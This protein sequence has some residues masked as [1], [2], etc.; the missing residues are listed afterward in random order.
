MICAFLSIA[1]ALGTELPFSESTKQLLNI[2]ALSSK[3]LERLDAFAFR[4]DNKKSSFKKKK[5]FINYLNDQAHKD[6]L[7]SYEQL[8]SFEELV[9]IGKYNCLTGSTFFALLLERYD[10]AYK[11]I[12]T[13]YHMFILIEDEG[14]QYLLDATDPIQGFETNASVIEQ[15]LAEYKAK[16]SEANKNSVSFQFDL[17]NQVKT[18]QLEGLLAY[19]S[20]VA[21]F[22][23]QEFFLAIDHLYDASLLYSSPRIIEMAKI[24]EGYLHELPHDNIYLKKIV[25]IKQMRSPLLA[26]N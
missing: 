6:I 7:L 22:N 8:T 25:K 10:V 18:S 3:D 20:S 2:E 4:M 19:N 23:K 9:S 12:E 14:K 5:N 11:V 17:F 16:N 21:A 26:S 15:R 1:V 13:N 24:I